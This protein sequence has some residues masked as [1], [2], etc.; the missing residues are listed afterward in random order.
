VAALLFLTPQLPYPPRQGTAIRNW[1]LIRHLAQRHAVSLVSFV[2][3]GQDPQSEILRA[4]C[5]PLVTIPVPRRTRADRLRSLAAGQADLVRRLWSPAFAEAVSQL[6]R[7]TRFDAVHFEGFEMT[8]Y[9]STVLAAASKAKTVYDAHNA[10]HILQRRAYQADVR[11][12]ARWLAALYSRLQVPRLARL[13]A[14]VCQAADEV[15][16]V[17][18][19]DGQ[20]LQRLVP[21]L[22]PLIVPNGI[23]LADYSEPGPRPPE[24]EGSDTLV[25]TGKMDYRPNVDAALWFADEILPRVRARRP[26]ARFLVVGQRPAPA[27][28]QR[29]G[30][31][32]VLVTG[33]VNDTRPYIG[34]A[35]V[36]VA[37]LR[38]GGGTRF[39][40]LEAMALS[41]PVVSTALGAEGF[42][43]RSENE[44][45]LADAPG[46]FAAAVV[47]LLETPAR[48]AELGAASQR[49]VQAGYDWSRLVPRL[50]ALYR[51]TG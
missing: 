46:D 49:F 5:Q 35:A 27:L 47:A 28:L 31:D 34:H 7:M 4:A 24:M 44:L 18:R 30:R 45:L 33:A 20:A 50:E 15:V 11:R 23:D 12:P 38:M 26:Q 41:R 37:P 29:N 21:A 51:P 25:F 22:S 43:V 32:G 39:K 10:E 1:G 42:D 6:L 3:E 48:A 9:L 14:A 17:S 13:E 8:P 2:E 19:E 36:Y 40:L 16:C